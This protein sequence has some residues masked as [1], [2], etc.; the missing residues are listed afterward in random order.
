VA[1]VFTVGWL[2]MESIGLSVVDKSYQ[3]DERIM[4]VVFECRP[5]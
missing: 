4:E 2:A 5:F 3:G 1:G